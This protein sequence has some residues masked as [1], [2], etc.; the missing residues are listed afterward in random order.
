MY[1]NLLGT[2]CVCVCVCVCVWERERESH[3]G[4]FLNIILTQF[5]DVYKPSDEEV[6]KP[7][8]YAANVRDQMA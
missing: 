4:N 1:L 7:K 8:L 6:E 2:V 5:L 3:V